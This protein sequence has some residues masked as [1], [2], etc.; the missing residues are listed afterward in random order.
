MDS[1]QTFLKYTYL[2]ILAVL[3]TLG[4]VLSFLVFSRKRFDKMKIT[5]AFRAM[6]IINTIMLLTN[7]AFAIFSSS[8]NINPDTISFI[9]IFL[10]KSLEYLVNFL[11]S[12]SAWILVYASFLRFITIRRTA[13]IKVL[14]SF[15]FN[16]GIISFI[17]T[18]GE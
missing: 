9:D 17:I 8:N 13:K 7:I 16:I 2:D 4:N 5:L 12:S 6:S 3:G 15:W 1:F 18:G 10:C 14:E 11:P